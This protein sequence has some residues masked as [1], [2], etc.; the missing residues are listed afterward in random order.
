MPI[1][2]GCWGIPGNLCGQTLLP[3]FPLGLHLLCVGLGLQPILE[4][5]DPTAA[6]LTKPFGWGEAITLSLELNLSK[7]ASPRAREKC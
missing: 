1:S 4:T 2:Q 5:A 7:G 6:P 3:L